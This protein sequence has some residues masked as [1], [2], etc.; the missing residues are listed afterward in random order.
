M[1]SVM[2]KKKSMQQQQDNLMM[3]AIKAYIDNLIRCNPN[4]E[5]LD[6]LIEYDRMTMEHGIEE[7]DVKMGFFYLG[8]QL[9]NR[10]SKNELIKTA[11]KSRN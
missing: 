5:N 3:E 6:Y 11:F 2:S 7:L 1:V 9:A 4:W 10:Q 8:Q